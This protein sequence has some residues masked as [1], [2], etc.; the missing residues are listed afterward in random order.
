MPC[1]DSKIAVNI[2]QEYSQCV[3][4]IPTTSSAEF[5]VPGVLPINHDTA[6]SGLVHYGNRLSHKAEN[7]KGRRVHRALNKS[8]VWYARTD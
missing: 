4:A 7:S 6:T 8:A 2:T 3:T 5:N 1:L